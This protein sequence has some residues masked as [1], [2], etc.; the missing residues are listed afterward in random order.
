[1]LVTV[2][3]KREPDGEPSELLRHLTYTLLEATI[4]LRF[5]VSSSS[6]AVDWTDLE[7]FSRPP[8][9]IPVIP[10]TQSGVFGHP[11]SEAA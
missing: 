6:L 9:H 11:K 8:M 2:L 1:V 10:D 7:S 4:G 5:K 3:E